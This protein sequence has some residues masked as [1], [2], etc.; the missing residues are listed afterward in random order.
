M[1]DLKKLCGEVG[2]QEAVI[3]GWG[4]AVGTK[5]DFRKW[6]KEDEEKEKLKMSKMENNFEFLYLSLSLSL[7]SENDGNFLSQNHEQL[8]Q[9]L[10]QQQKLLQQQYVQLLRRH[11]RDSML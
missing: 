3:G 11:S 8:Q 6:S 1:A 4:A 10:Q 2:A 7:L 9:L 5:V